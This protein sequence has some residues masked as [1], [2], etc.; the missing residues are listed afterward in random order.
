MIFRLKLIGRKLISVMFIGAASKC[1]RVLA[2]SEHVSD[3]HTALAGR[4]ARRLSAT[5][6]VNT[7]AACRL[8]AHTS[9][10]IQANRFSAGNSFGLISRQRS[11]T[12][13]D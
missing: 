9:E 6:S 10:R 7:D 12:L 2:P 4:L 5:S 8:A 1:S 11:W 13:V 3:G